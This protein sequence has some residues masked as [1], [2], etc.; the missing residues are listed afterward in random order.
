MRASWVYW[1]ESLRSGTVRYFLPFSPPLLEFMKRKKVI[2]FFG[3]ATYASIFQIVAILM[4]A[5]K[6][7]AY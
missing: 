5:D 1:K 4:T 7:H 3:V 6:D 2:F